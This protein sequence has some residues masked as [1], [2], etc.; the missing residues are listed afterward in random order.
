MFKLS[1]VELASVVSGS[2]ILGLGRHH[3]PSQNACKG[4]ASPILQHSSLV[5]DG[6]LSTGMEGFNPLSAAVLAGHAR[7]GFPGPSWFPW[8]QLRCKPRIFLVYSS[9]LNSSLREGLAPAGFWRDAE[10]PSQPFTTHVHMWLQS[11]KGVWGDGICKLHLLPLLIA[12]GGRGRLKGR[13]QA[14]L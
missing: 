7:P 4:A 13:A 6:L 9:H 5:A 1:P 2:S 12:I 14:T 10:E 8:H 3:P 11:G